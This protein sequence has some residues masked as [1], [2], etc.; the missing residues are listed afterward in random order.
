MFLFIAFFS[1]LE[2]TRLTTLGLYTK[3]F[4]NIPDIK[5]INLASSLLLSLLFLQLQMC[6]MIVV[7]FCVT[8]CLY[9][10]NCDVCL[11]VCHN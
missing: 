9:Q 3:I 2:L 5:I 6:Y 11:T 4:R 7:C 10:A 1:L 8:H